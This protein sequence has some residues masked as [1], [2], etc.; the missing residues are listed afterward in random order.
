MFGA[1]GRLDGLLPMADDG[2]M[3]CRAMGIE[4]A[5]RCAG[6]EV[7]VTAYGRAALDLLAAQ[8]VATKGGDRLAPVTV[9]VPSNYAAISTR[10]ALAAMAGGAA[11]LTFMTLY[12]L[13]ERLGGSRL[14]AAG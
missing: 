9:I 10:R 2:R 11:N 14:A 8:I 4:T 5:D 13:A 1:G 3:G 6:F 7:H 12:R